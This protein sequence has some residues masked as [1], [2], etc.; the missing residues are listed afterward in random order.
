MLNAITC[1]TCGVEEPFTDGADPI[2]LHD[3]GEFRCDACGA[4]YVFG[5]LA[6]TI[7]VEPFDGPKGTRWVRVRVQHP[8]TRA[9]LYVVDVEH[10]PMSAALARNI[11]AIGV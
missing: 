2:P 7:V 8:Q 6:P 11:L 4:R 3:V 1:P 5:K 9:D 10:G